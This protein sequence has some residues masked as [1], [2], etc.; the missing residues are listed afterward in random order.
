MAN[1]NFSYCNGFIIGCIFIWIIV[2]SVWTSNNDKIKKY[3]SI[4]TVVLKHIT[5]NEGSNS[6]PYY[7]GFIV[8][9]FQL[10]NI[11][12]LCTT[13]AKKDSDEVYLNNWL[14]QA[15]PNGTIIENNYNTEDVHIC[16]LTIDKRKDLLITWIIF[17]CL[18]LLGIIS[19]LIAKCIMDDKNRTRETIQRMQL[20]V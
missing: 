18:F 8:F 6:D 19:S 3:N 5:I 7:A 12:Y 20:S 10:N 2:F 14:S 16:R 17:L 4:S 15:F 9:Q 1:N 11:T 13:L